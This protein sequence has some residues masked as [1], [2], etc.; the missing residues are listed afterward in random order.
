MFSFLSPASAKDLDPTDNKSPVLVSI[1]LNKSALVEGE[2]ALVTVV[3]RD[4]K[5]ELKSWPIVLFGAPAD[6]PG[7]ISGGVFAS[8]GRGLMN[9]V[10]NSQYVEQTFEYEVK[11]PSWPGLYYGFNIQGIVDKN[12]NQVGFDLKTCVNKNIYGSPQALSFPELVPTCKT[13]FSVRLMSEEEKAQAK[14]KTDAE[15]KAKADAEAKA[16]ADAEAKAK[17]DAEAKAIEIAEKQACD[18]RKKDLSTLFETLIIFKKANPARA[19]DVNSTLD[20]LTSALRSSCV[21]E[22]TL[23]DFKLEVRELLLSASRK[24]TITC[25]KGKLT[26]KVTA[27]NP[28]CPAGYKK[29]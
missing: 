6:S 21:A 17:A 8:G 3:I 24:T 14:A 28:K 27:F 25:V 22:V 16:K 7:S 4:D 15:A 13:S 29:K 23:N 10:I 18:A 1:N 26:K 9:T 5:N 20:R 11:A 12:G 2:V 19:A